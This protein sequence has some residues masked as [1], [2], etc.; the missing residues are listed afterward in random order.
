VFLGKELGARTTD[1]G[2]YLDGK[3]QYAMLAATEEFA[4]V[5]Q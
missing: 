4:G 1:M 3:V 2:C 5:E